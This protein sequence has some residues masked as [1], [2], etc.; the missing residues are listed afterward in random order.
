MNCFE[1]FFSLNKQQFKSFE[2]QNLMNEMLRNKSIFFPVIDISKDPMPMKIS[3]NEFFGIERTDVEIT[4]MEYIFRGREL[5]IGELNSQSMYNEK[6]T[7]LNT[8]LAESTTRENLSKWNDIVS[9]EKFNSELYQGWLRG[10]IEY[11]FGY[12]K[13]RWKPFPFRYRNG[14]FGF[15]DC[16]VSS[17]RFQ[18]DQ[19]ENRINYYSMETIDGNFYE[20]G[21]FIEEELNEHPM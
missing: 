9:E 10:F 15:S 2:T 5:K 11:D 19:K 3:K 7:F 12:F 21:K 8:I 13:N 1:H 14:I 20:V 16:L 4:Y 17:G 18:I 6:K